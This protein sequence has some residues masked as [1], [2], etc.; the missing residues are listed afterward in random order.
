M[1]KNSSVA[2]SGGGTFG[3]I[4]YAVDSELTE[5]WAVVLY[6]GTGDFSQG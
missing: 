6:I 4:I 2:L 3:F 1:A 5:T